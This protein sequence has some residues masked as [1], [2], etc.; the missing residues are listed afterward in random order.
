MRFYLPLKVVFQGWQDETFK[1]ERIM[2]LLVTER[3]H[4]CSAAN[5]EGRLHGTTHWTNIG[6]LVAYSRVE[7]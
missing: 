6:R 3:W 7:V 4:G 2:I 5:F 1:L